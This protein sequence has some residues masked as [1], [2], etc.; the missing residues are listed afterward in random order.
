VQNLILRSS[1]EKKGEA[2]L[3][4]SLGEILRADFLVPLGL[5][6]NNSLWNLRVPV[7]R[8]ARIICERRGITPY[9]VASWALFQYQR[10][11]LARP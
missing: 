6:M 5:S 10:P 8:I 9:R 2:P 1:D 3:S 11:I 4:D 7:T